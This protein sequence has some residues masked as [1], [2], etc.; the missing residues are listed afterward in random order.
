MSDN[1]GESKSASFAKSKGVVADL[2]EVSLPEGTQILTVN[3]S[4]SG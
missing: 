2:K 1:E 3:T 4:T